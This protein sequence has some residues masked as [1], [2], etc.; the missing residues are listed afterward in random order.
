MEVSAR[1]SA[2]PYVTSRRQQ[3]TLCVVRHDPCIQLAAGHVLTHMPPESLVEESVPLT[4][5]AAHG[6]FA[7]AERASEAEPQSLGAVDR[8]AATVHEASSANLSL[9]IDELWISAQTSLAM[10]SLL[11]AHGC[12]AARLHLVLKGD[13]VADRKST[14]MP[15]GE[16]GLLVRW[17]VCNA[18]VETTSPDATRRSTDWHAMEF[19]LVR[20]CS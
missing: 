19:T 4:S 2:Q 14:G 18:R 20:R 8:I 16:L 7:R 1:P 6:G 12:S 15:S 11:S 17:H 13:T 3:H 9:V 5:L 10:C